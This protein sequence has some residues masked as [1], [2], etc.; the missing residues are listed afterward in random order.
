MIDFG[1]MC[2]VRPSVPPRGWLQRTQDMLDAIERIDRYV[3]GMTYES[4]CETP[5]AVDT[6]VRNLIIIGEA[7]N[8]LPDDVKDQRPHLPWQKM[9]DMRNFVTHV[10]W[11]ADLEIV[12]DTVHEHLPPLQHALM[13][14]RTKDTNE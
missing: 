14:L 7:A 12:W 13:Q 10:Y 8:Q 11:G 9:V 4:F 3:E 5:M 6:V 1:V 2:C